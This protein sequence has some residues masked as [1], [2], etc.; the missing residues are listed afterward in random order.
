MNNIDLKTDFLYIV[1]G[2]YNCRKIPAATF[3]DVSRKSLTGLTTFARINRPL[4]DPDVTPVFGIKSR[5]HVYV[6]DDGAIHGFYDRRHIFTTLHPKGFML[7]KAHFDAYYDRFTRINPPDDDG[8]QRLRIKIRHIPVTIYGK[9]TTAHITHHALK[10]I[11]MDGPPV[12]IIQ[13]AMV[14]VPDMPHM[15]L[16]DVGQRDFAV[17]NTIDRMSN[18]TGKRIRIAT[19]YHTPCKGDAG[20]DRLQQPITVRR[21]IFNP[22]GRRRRP[23]RRN[24]ISRMPL[25]G[26]TAS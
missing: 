19:A 16:Y 8:L 11:A 10:P 2:N 9:R 25:Y 21:Q 13:Y 26:P 14:S 5:G 23:T 1:T 15:Y 20:F 7:A 4:P 3:C 17:K 24:R 22:L 18:F 12:N 6:H